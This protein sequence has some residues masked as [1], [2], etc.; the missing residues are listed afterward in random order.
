MQVTF[1]FQATIEVAD[2]G[3]LL[4][5]REITNLLLSDCQMGD[6]LPEELADQGV[7]GGEVRLATEADQPRLKISFW[8]PGAPTDGLLRLLEKDVIAQLE[9]GLGE[10]GFEVE[11]EDYCVLL[12]A[13]TTSSPTIDVIDDGRTI[14]EIPLV[15]IASRDGNLPLLK[16]NIEND[17][18]NVNQ[19]F[20][21]YSAL[22]YAILNGHV[23]AVGAFLD[24]GADPNLP[25][26]HGT[27]PLEHCALTNALDDNGSSQVTRL[28]LNAGAN[29]RHVVPN[30]ESAKSYAEARGKNGMAAM[31]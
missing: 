9:D 28:L 14:S 31:L 8:M 24:A 13:D 1:S 30:G 25:D 15:A 3:I 19:L 23:E 16:S 26:L 5:N 27:R 21:G 11:F 2:S 4:E 18:T 7:I 20:Q 10:G 22:H 12:R 6:Y 17:E 29:P